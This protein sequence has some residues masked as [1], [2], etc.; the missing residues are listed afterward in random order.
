MKRDDHGRCHD[1]RADDVVIGANLTILITLAQEQMNR[2]ALVGKPPI[3]DVGEVSRGT[4]P[5]ERIGSKSQATIRAVS[6]AG[7]I[8]STRLRRVI[9]LELVVGGDVAGSALRVGQDAVLQFSNE[10]VVR[11]AD[12]AAFVLDDG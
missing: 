10:G 4:S 5:E 2:G 3:I 7:S 9:K 1:I 11:L 8:Q 6:P 12:A